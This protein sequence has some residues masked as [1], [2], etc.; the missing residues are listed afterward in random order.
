MGEGQGSRTRSPGAFLGE[1]A[2]GDKWLLYGILVPPPPPARQSTGGLPYAAAAVTRKLERGAPVMLAQSARL[3][4]VTAS[5]KA[6]LR[7]PT[8]PLAAQDLE[9]TAGRAAEIAGVEFDLESRK[10]KR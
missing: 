9:P 5:G 10:R 3:R 8:P 7:V 4:A 2:W 6:H 1:G